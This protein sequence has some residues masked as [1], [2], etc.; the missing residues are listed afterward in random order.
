MGRS[1]WCVQA[2]VHYFL[3][4]TINK[5]IFSIIN[6]LIINRLN[7]ERFFQTFLDQRCSNL[8]RSIS[9]A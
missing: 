5:S 7:G 3:Y 4:H 2:H 9:A 6:R 8:M 1:I